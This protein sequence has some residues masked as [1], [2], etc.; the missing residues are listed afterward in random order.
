MKTQQDPR[1]V[2]F[3][4]CLFSEEGWRGL[5][6]SLPTW[7]SQGA[8]WEK[9]SRKRSFLSRR[10]AASRVQVQ[11]SHASVAAAGITPLPAQVKDPDGRPPACLRV[12]LGGACKCTPS[13]PL[14][15][16]PKWISYLLGRCR[17]RPSRGAPKPVPLLQSPAPLPGSSHPCLGPQ[18]ARDGGRLSENCVS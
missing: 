15:P 13:P 18:A 9:P 8:C 6:P 10:E 1:P 4:S 2:F 12:R 17:H 14:R 16:L 11:C 7:E 5:E 3:M